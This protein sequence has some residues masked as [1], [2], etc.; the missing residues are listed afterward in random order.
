MGGF[1]WLLFDLWPRRKAYMEKVGTRKL[2]YCRDQ[3]GD[4][5]N[6][7]PLFRIGARAHGSR[8]S[9]RGEPLGN[10]PKS[11]AKIT[12]EQKRVFGSRFLGQELALTRLAVLLG[13]DL[14]ETDPRK[15]RRG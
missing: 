11:G 12:L 9:S 7:Q 8:R 15:R 13:E 1:Q 6:Y 5:L 14:W 4:I 2:T 3:G 10:G